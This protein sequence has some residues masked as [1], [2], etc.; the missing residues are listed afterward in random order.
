MPLDKM[1]EWSVEVELWVVGLQYLKFVTKYKNKNLGGNRSAA[2]VQSK[3]PPN[4]DSNE[5]PS[6][7]L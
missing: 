4:S 7:N 1:W 2:G 5:A 3:T 6:Q